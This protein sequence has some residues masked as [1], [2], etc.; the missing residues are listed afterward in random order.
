VHICT[1]I[2]VVKSIKESMVTY[3]SQGVFSV[4]GS[5]VNVT[6][7]GDN[8]YIKDQFG[9]MLFIDLYTCIS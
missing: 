9:E 2:L 1:W 5:I 6:A 7:V 8:I 3:L 4:G